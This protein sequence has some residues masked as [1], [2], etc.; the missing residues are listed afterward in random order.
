MW[1]Y[2]SRTHVYFILVSTPVHSK[3]LGQGNWKKKMNALVI[4]QYIHT[5]LLSLQSPFYPFSYLTSQYVCKEGNVGHTIPILSRWNRLR[6]A[7]KTIL[8]A[9]I[10]ECFLCAKYCATSLLKFSQLVSYLMINNRAECVQKQTN[11]QNWASQNTRPR[12]CRKWVT[13]G[14]VFSSK[15]C[16]VNPMLV[17]C[18][19]MCSDLELRTLV[20][21][22]LWFKFT[23]LFGRQNK[24]VY[25]GT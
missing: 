2:K 4:E 10:M 3:Y 14:F 19:S 24:A 6:K 16:L 11:K 5:D 15:I 1:R 18:Q 13:K 12:L 22:R 8:L 9:K 17:K 21:E 7:N 20:S 23:G 25:V